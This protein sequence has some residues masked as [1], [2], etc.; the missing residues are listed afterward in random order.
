STAET[1]DSSDPSGFCAGEKSSYQLLF[2]Y[3][4]K[5]IDDQNQD[6]SAFIEQLSKCM[7]ANPDVIISIESSASTV[8]TSTFKSNNQ[9]AE[10]RAWS[11]E[12]KI[13][14]SLVKNGLKKNQI[15]FATPIT[16]VQ[17]PEYKKDAVEQASV[18]EQF[19]YIKIKT[20]IKK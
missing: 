6:Y 13:R 4:K 20:S 7:K 16:L 17:G 8:P 5:E 10:L 12:K 2:K 19:Q 18:Y 1:K 9:L 11:A 15:K 14:N 3:N